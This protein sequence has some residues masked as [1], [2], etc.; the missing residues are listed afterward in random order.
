[1]NLQQTQIGK[2]FNIPLYR[3]LWQLLLGIIAIISLWYML[4]GRVDANE[5]DIDARGC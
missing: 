4:V 5:K 3:F 1:M 2:T